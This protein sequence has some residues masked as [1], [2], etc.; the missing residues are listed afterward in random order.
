M[1]R[2]RANV[3]VDRKQYDDYK[4][5]KITFNVRT[6]TVYQGYID[7]EHAFAHVQK[8][9][10]SSREPRGVDMWSHMVR[11]VRNF[12][13]MIFE[14]PANTKWCSCC[15]D[16]VNVNG[17]SPDKRNRDGLHVWCKTCRNDHERRRYWAGKQVA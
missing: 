10:Y 2:K 3:I 6:T 15:G 13:P 11:S 17:F 16:W 9:G 12:E 14:A 7:G 4:L 8:S 5:D 1:G